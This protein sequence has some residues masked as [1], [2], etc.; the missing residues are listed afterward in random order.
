MFTVALAGVAA[1]TAT[2][3]VATRERFVDDEVAAREAAGAVREPD[4]ASRPG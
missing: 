2:G 1:L 4:A 3:W